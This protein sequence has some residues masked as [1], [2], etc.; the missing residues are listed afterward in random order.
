MTVTGT[1]APCL[2]VMW[3]DRTVTAVCA[4]QTAGQGP[5]LGGVAAPL[6]AAGEEPVSG[7]EGL[8]LQLA[9]KTAGFMSGGF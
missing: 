2:L 5:E 8:S 4:G 3:K 6:T 1:S 7:E 9:L